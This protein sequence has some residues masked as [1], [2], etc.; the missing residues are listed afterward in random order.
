MAQNHG[1]WVKEDEITSADMK[2]TMSDQAIRQGL[3]D[4]CDP[5]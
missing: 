1:V 2:D 3:T 4:T 5:G